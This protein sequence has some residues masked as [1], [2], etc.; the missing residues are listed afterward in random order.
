MMIMITNW[1]DLDLGGV[2]DGGLTFL[3]DTSAAVSGDFRGFCCW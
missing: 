1:M 2:G 3:E